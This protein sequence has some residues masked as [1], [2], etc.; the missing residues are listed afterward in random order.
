MEQELVF[1]GNNGQAVT[2]SLKISEVFGKRNRD[3]LRDIRNL[4]CSKEFH[5]RNFALMVNMSELP[6]GG[7]QKS[8]YYQITKNG[9]VFLVM[10]Y[11]GAKAAQFKESYISAFDR[12]EAQLHAGSHR[13]DFSQ[14][15]RKDL[16]RM[17]YESELEREHL[18][19][20]LSSA[21]ETSARTNRP[22]TYV[23]DRVDRLERIVLQA[24]EPLYSQRMKPELPKRKHSNSVSA[25]SKIQRLSPGAM[26]IREMCQLLAEKNHINVASKNV[27]DWFRR[28]GWLLS[29][30]SS[31][32]APSE[33][34]QKNGWMVFSP[35]GTTGG[36]LQYAT[37][38]VT[39]KGYE[40]FAKL[41]IQ[42]GGV[43]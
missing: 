41:L 11:T 28:E 21:Q 24:I 3:V 37:P 32:N 1:L 22:S 40:H 7:S 2:N 29:E 18:A 43:L 17:L 33:E 16:A 5:E 9:F 25:R 14:L 6:Q 19:E 12:M 20:E 23:P 42:K 15:S 35:S 34:M 36:G 38:Y 8:E 30:S 13:P 26:L 31:F 27:F 4:S 39:L 10:G